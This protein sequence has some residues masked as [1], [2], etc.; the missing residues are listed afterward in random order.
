MHCRHGHCAM[1][2]LRQDEGI[3]VQMVGAVHIAG[4]LTFRTPRH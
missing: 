4:L 2:G 1:A 3:M